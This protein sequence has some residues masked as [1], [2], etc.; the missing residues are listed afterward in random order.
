MEIAF[1]VAAFDEDRDCARFTKVG[2]EGVQRKSP[3]RPVSLMSFKARRLVNQAEIRGLC[4]KRFTADITLDCKQMPETGARISSGELVLGILPERK[5][6]WPECILLQKKLPCPLING[7]RY[8][9]VEFPGSLCI[10]DSLK[11]V[12]VKGS[13]AADV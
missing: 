6:C 7:V 5:K 4:Y 2:M 9:S 11:V 3:D 1:K 10:G 12:K 8:A 13:D